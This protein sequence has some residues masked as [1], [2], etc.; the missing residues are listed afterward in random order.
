M[1]APLL[2]LHGDRAGSAPPHFRALSGD[3]AW[4]VGEMLIASSQGGNRV[5]LVGTD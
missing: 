1:S 4:L 3:R 5:G 2:S